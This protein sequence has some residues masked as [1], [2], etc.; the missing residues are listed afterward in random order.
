VDVACDIQAERSRWILGSEDF[1]TGTDLGQT[2][3][4]KSQ[5][6]LPKKESYGEPGNH[7][8]GGLEEE[9]QKVGRKPEVGLQPPRIRGEG[10][11]DSFVKK[12]A[13]QSGRSSSGTVA[14]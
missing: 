13:G 3:Y 5:L 14:F 6:R 2:D 4:M 10:G 8:E 1:L 7:S 11:P 12:V 9:E